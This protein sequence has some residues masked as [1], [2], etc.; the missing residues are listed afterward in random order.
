MLVIMW[1]L[2]HLDFDCDYDCDLMIS[3]N[4]RMNTYIHN[5]QKAEVSG[6]GP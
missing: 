2:I 1:L 5:Q 4:G 3:N 6:N